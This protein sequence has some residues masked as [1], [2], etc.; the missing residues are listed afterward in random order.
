MELF[1]K[2]FKMKHI[3]TTAFHP[4]SNGSLERAH[5]VVKDLIRTCSAERQNEWDQNLKVISMGYNTSV[6]ETTGYTPFELTFGR[7]AN[8]PSTIANTASLDQNEL[9]KLWK[10][11]HDYLAKARVITEKAKLKNKATQDSRII[12]TQTILKV[13]DQ[14]LIHNDHK[15]SKLDTE[16]IGPATII[17]AILPTYTIDFNHKI[18]KVHGNR[19]KLF[20]TAQQSLPSCSATTP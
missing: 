9:F 18:Q 15:S 6:H 5:G 8:L 14:V 3:R 2:A 17:N 16:W 13:G 20:L 12:R 1:E 7:L 19:L 11:K 4:Q 10:A